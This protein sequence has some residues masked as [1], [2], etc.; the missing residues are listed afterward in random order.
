MKQRERP[1]EKSK[2]E[3]GRKRGR[4]KTGTY[5]HQESGLGN[6]TKKTTFLL[7]DDKKLHVL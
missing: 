4:R 1:S 5:R 2:K 7:Q 3:E 6:L